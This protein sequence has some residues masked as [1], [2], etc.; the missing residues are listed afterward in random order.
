MDQDERWT[1]PLH[2]L[3]WTILVCGLI[4]VMVIFLLN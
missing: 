2:I 1:I 4:A 3:M